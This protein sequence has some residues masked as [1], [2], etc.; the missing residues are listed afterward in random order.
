MS[1]IAQKTSQALE[2]HGRRLW[3]PLGL[4]PLQA[5]TEKPCKLFLLWVLQTRGLVAKE[6]F[7]VCPSAPINSL[8]SLPFQLCVELRKG[9]RDLA[10]I[11]TAMK[12]RQA[13]HDKTPRPSGNNPQAT[14]AVLDLAFCFLPPLLQF[15][16]R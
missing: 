16:P 1:S 12:G 8:S 13:C 5:D 15:R 9:V 3:R 14:C 11:L 7:T 6:T 2:I 4:S 10:H